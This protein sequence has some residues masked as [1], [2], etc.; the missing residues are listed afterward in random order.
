MAQTKVQVLAG[1]AAQVTSQ[2]I[3]GRILIQIQSYNQLGYIMMK[4]LFK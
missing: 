1:I 3:K 4:L 2:I